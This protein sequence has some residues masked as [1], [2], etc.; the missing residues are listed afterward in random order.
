MPA[1]GH[2]VAASG[3]VVRCTGKL[4]HH[5]RVLAHLDAAPSQFFG[6]RF[7]FFGIAGEGLAHHRFVIGFALRVTLARLE[8]SGVEDRTIFDEGEVVQFGAQFFDSFLVGG[9]IR[10]STFAVAS[11][12]FDQ[13]IVP[14]A[15][16]FMDAVAPIARG[17]TQADDAYLVALRSKVEDRLARLE[18]HVQHRATAASVTTLLQDH[19]FTVT[20]RHESLFRLRFADGSALLRHHF[21]RLGFVPAWRDVATPGREAETFA[22]LEAALNAR[23]AHEGE[24][25]LSVPM[26]GVCARR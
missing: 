16:A 13:G 20:E 19:G 11:E 12:A 5:L 3:D 1:G 6:L 8:L 4:V 24:L 2:C 9:L 22:A 10:L 18:A 17:L 15:I 23:A 7:V 25:V 26:V 21:I 14:D